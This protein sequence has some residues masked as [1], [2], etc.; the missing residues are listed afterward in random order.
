M[1]TSPNPEF[2]YYRRHL[3]HRRRYYPIYGLLLVITGALGFFGVLA[4]YLD[5]PENIAD[6]T[7][8]LWFVHVGFLFGFLI[9]ILAGLFLGIYAIKAPSTAQIQ[10]YR[11]QERQR[12]YLQAQ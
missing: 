6:I 12:V 1:S 5:H 2:E 4:P 10:R 3:L 9:M 8:P 11:R 7:R